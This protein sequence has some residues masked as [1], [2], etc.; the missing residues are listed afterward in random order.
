MQKCSTKLQHIKFSSIIKGL[1]KHK[2]VKAILRKKNGAGGMRPLDCR[3]Y[4]E[5]AVINSKV[6][7]QK[8]KYTSM[9]QDR[10][11]RSKPMLN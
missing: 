8:Q 3:L 9:E 2:I 10:K 6:L 11:P 5:A 4:T 7:A 1:W